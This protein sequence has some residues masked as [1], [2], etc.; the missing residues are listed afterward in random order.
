MYTNVINSVNGGWSD[1]SY[2]ACTPSCGGG[3]KTKTRTCDNPSVVG[4][5]IP[6]SGE[7]TGTDACNTD[8]CPGKGLYT[9]LVNFLPKT[10]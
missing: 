3:T 5:G 4:N 8:S 1:W 6:C 10:K 9:Y 2:T 7:E